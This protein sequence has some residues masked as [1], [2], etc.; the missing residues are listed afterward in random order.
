[1]EDLTGRAVPATSATFTTGNAPDVTAPTVIATS[2]I[3]GDPSVPLNSV[4]EW[5]YSEPV[6]AATV[7][8]QTNV[9]YD[10]SVG[11]VPGAQLTLST[12][13]RTVT[14]VPP[15]L[16]PGKL[17]AVF[18]GSV[19]DLAGNVGGNVSISFTTTTAADNTPPL[20][21]V[22]NPADGATAVP[23][24]TRIRLAFNE[25]ISAT[26]LPNIN[27]LVSG[28]PLPVASRVL[29]NGDRVVTLTL[30]GLLAPNTA[31]TISARVRDRAGN[32]MP[33]AATSTFTTGSGVDLINLSSTVTASPVNNAT[34]VAVGT[35]PSVTFTEAIDPTS[36]IYGGN[37]GVVLLVAA[38]NQPVPITYSFS[39]DRRTVT[40]TPVSALAAGTQYRIQVSSATTDLAGNSF[41]TSVQFLFT[42]QP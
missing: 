34:G 16:A 42:T 6:D 33:S 8:N 27:I 4:F 1:V 23:T 38:T 41:P 10:Y 19:A 39:S 12:D 35:A 32:L 24:N 29:S 7:L 26:T 15:T 17:Y 2:T 3:S 20:V 22:M 11:Y 5:T 30:T 40:M 14:L 37:G 31:H 25:P 21:V 9:F 36:V 18:L 28:L 13:A